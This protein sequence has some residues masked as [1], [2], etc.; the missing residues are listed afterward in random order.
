MYVGFFGVGSILGGRVK[1]VVV[2]IHDNVLNILVR[3]SVSTILGI[4]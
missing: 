2:H 3:K 1:K 4:D